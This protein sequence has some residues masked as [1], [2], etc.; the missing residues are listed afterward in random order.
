MPLTTDAVRPSFASRP[1]FLSALIPAF[2][3][4]RSTASSKFPSVSINAFLLS[5]QY[6]EKLSGKAFILSGENPLTFMSLIEKISKLVKNNS[7]LNPVIKTVDPPENLLKIEFRNF[8]G[9]TKELRSITGWKP[10]V[11]LDEGLTKTMHSFL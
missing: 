10:Q 9:S 1:A 2:L 6:S 8:S 11:T 3:R 4:S 5:A 7:S